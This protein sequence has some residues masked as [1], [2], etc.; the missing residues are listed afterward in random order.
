MDVSVLDLARGADAA[1]GEIPSTLDI[2]RQLTGIVS[3]VDTPRNRLWVSVQGS[4]PIAMEYAAGSY[5]PGEMVDVDRDTLA[6]VLKF[7]VRGRTGGTPGGTLPTVPPAA[8]TTVAAVTVVAP[9][10]SGTWRQTRYDNW[11]A[12]RAAYGGRATLYQG[13]GFGSGQLYGLALYGNQIRD[14]NAIAITAMELTLRDA[15]MAIPSRPTMDVRAATNTDASGAPAPTGVTMTGP[16][17][18]VGAVGSLAIDASLL[19][20]FRTGALQAL[21]TVGVGTGEYNAV[22]GTSDADG[23]ALTVNYTRA[24]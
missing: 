17:L 2:T 14:L 5:T 20:S 3:S 4:N 15:S 11:N 10:W 6:G 19:A 18:G 24:I 16:A 21:A 23:M 8:P 9:T 13:D 22:R 7:Y 1:Q 12:T